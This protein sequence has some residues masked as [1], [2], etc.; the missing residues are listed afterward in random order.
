MRIGVTVSA[1]PGHL[2]AMTA[3]ARRLASRGHEVMCIGMPDAAKGVASAGNRVP[4]S[5]RVLTDSEATF[6]HAENDVQMQLLWSDHEPPLLVGRR[7][8]RQ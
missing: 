2:N 4:D 8:E 7:C 5:G 6:P 3:L 1:A